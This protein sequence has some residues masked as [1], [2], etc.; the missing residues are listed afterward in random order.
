MLKLRFFTAIAFLFSLATDGRSAEVAAGGSAVAVSA[1]PITTNGRVVGTV[2]AGH[3]VSVL[4]VQN[5]TRQAVVSYQGPNGTKLV[6]LVALENLI[7]VDG[8][9]TPQAASPTTTAP[10]VPSTAAAAA[11]PAPAATLDLSQIHDATDV[12]RFFKTDKAAAKEKCEGQRVKFKGVIDKVD[13]DTATSGGDMPILVLKTASGL[14]RLKIKL[15]NSLATNDAFFQRYNSSIPSWWWGYGG[16][17]AIDYRLA[18][19]K[20][21]QVRAV[22]R[23]NNTTR[24]SDGTSTVSRSRSN[25][26]WFTIFKVGEPVSVEGTCKGLYMDVEFENGAVVSN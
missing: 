21:I 9:A 23:Y 12:A 25:S 19:L 5:A 8:G 4:G 20:E 16:N 26:P 15:S 6:G 1:A 14:P 3:S 7:A 10:F 17:R 2:E 22:Y 11:T 18:E 24:W 13:L